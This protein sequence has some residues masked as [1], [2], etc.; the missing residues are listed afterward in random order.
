MKNIL[1]ATTALVATAGIASADVSISGFA[2]VGIFDNGSGDMQLFN[3]IDVTFSMTGETD[4]G[5]S[6]GASVD[7]DEISDTT[8]NAATDNNSAGGIAANISGSF[9]TVTLGDTDGASDWA[10]TETA[11]GGSMADDHTAHAGYSGNSPLDGVADGQILRWNN[12][13]GAMGVAVSFEQAA[14]GAT[15]AND[16]TVQI[17]LKY[18]MDA[19]SAT[20]GLGIG[21]AD[22]GSQT[23]VG[24]AA[25]PSKIITDASGVVT[26][27]AAG[28][29]VAGTGESTLQLGVPAVANVTGDTNGMGISLSVASGNLTS[30]LNYS[31]GE[32]LGVDTSHVALGFGVTMDAL[33]VGVNWGEFDIN[34]VK[35]NGIGVAVNYNLGGGAVFQLG[36]GDGEGTDT[37]SMGLA[38][39]F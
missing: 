16:D 15:S 7:L 9:G 35:T 28:T 18:S 6:F 23:A 37:M 3:D 5:I 34:N 24:N 8:V 31:D 25:T 19:G 26:T 13:V 33:T 32:V 17:G 10:M 36:Y 22:A 12:T 14:N 38:L 39:S 30:V 11:I 4:S 27:T 2:E 21:Y 29:A 20:I 1:F